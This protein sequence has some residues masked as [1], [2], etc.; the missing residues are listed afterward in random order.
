MPLFDSLMS[1]NEGQER[2]DQLRGS[3]P[4]HLTLYTEKPGASPPWLL[5]DTLIFCVATIKV[6]HEKEESIFYA[7]LN[8]PTPEI[9]NRAAKGREPS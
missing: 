3:M 8:G 6:S 2:Q 7:K 4:P 5:Q 1:L 9:R